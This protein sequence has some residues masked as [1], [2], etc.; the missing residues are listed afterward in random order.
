MQL[1][2]NIAYNIETWCTT[3]LYWDSSTI[4][5]GQG[6]QSKGDN[7][8]SSKQKYKRQQRPARQNQLLKLGK[9]REVTARR[10]KAFGVS[11]RV[12]GKCL[13]YVTHIC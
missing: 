12:S 5:G 3:G 10:Q 13:R 2:A 11:V 8:A 4:I 6:E 1:V 9:V 7:R